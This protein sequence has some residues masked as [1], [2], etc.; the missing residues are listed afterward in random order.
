[1][2]F[3][4]IP[5]TNVGNEFSLRLVD[6]KPLAQVRNHIFVVLG[7]PNDGNGFVNVQQDLF[8]SHQHMQF[9]IFDHQIKV[10]FPF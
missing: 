9:I 8:Q 10:N 3:V 4:Q 2:F 6:V 7:F 5:Q 1:M